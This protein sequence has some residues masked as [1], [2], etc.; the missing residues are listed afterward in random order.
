MTKH[1]YD[2]SLS[3]VIASEDY[4]D[5]LWSFMFYLIWIS[6]PWVL[7]SCCSCAGY[8]LYCVCCCCE[9]CSGACLRNNDV[10]ESD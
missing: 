4:E 5:E 3:D 6:L 7:L 10:K 9:E 8:C 2:Y 1:G